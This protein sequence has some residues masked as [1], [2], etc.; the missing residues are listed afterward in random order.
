MTGILLFIGINFL[1]F[2]PAYILNFKNQPELL[3]SYLFSKTSLK[4]RLRILL[5]KN[6]SDFFRINFDFAI[7]FILLIYFK[8]NEFLISICTVF[9]V[10]GTIT[11]VYSQLITIFFERDI[12]ILNDLILGKSGLIFLGRLRYLVI[13]VS[14]LVILVLYFCF[15]FLI[16]ILIRQEFHEP[17]LLVLY[18]YICI[19][20]LYKINERPIGDY[21]M[22]TVPDRNVA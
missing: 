11:F 8:N 10:L 21:I 17:S 16:S 4:N 14:F 1:C 18:F 15:E 22:R 9:C 2:L 3:P 7:I 19:S 20:G 5:W 6:S 13:P 12:S